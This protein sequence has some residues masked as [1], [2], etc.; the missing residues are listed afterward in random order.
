MNEIVRDQEA[1][2]AARAQY[3]NAF[4]RLREQAATMLGLGA[5]GPALHIARMAVM[6][7]HA[8]A[9]EYPVRRR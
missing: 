7:R 1:A 8:A 5:T 2:C 4:F 3:A 9:S 6:V